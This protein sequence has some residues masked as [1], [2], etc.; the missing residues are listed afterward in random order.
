MLFRIVGASGSLSYCLHAVGWG[1]LD[2][3]FLILGSLQSLKKQ[4]KLQ[5][6]LGFPNYP[7]P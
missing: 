7:K 2:I 5:V 6:L 3:H 1:S 4:L